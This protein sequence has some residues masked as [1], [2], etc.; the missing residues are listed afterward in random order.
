VRLVSRSCLDLRGTRDRQGKPLTA[1]ILAVADE[2]AAAAGL[3]MS[4]SEGSPVILIRGY[5]FMPSSE[6]AASIILP[7]RRRPLPLI[8]TS[9]KNLVGL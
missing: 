3:L 9:Y 7:R 2:L 5:R 1:T 8:P 6:L 4:K